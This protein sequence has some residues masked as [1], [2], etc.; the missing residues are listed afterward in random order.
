M[1]ALGVRVRGVVHANECDVLAEGGR[2]AVE[3]L[4]VRGGRDV[5]DGVGGAPLQRRRSI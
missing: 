5:G 3:D 1:P 4:P 2:V